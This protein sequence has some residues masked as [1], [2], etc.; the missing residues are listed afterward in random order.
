M[1]PYYKDPEIRHPLFSKT[2]KSH[3]R[4]TTPKGNLG[5]PSPKP[6]PIWN[7]YDSLI[8]PF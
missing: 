3:L 5:A 1:D 4:P 7:P 6:Y 2:P 8:D